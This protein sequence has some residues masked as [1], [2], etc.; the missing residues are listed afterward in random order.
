MDPAKSQ[1]DA[2]DQAQRDA[3]DRSAQSSA[4]R[5]DRLAALI[6]TLLTAH[7]L[8]LFLAGGLVALATVIA[9]DYALWLPAWARFVALA[10]FITG[11]VLYARRWLVPALR[12][13]PDREQLALRLERTTAGQEAGLEGLLASGVGLAGT[14]A[15]APHAASTQVNAQLADQPPS[16]AHAKSD[17]DQLSVLDALAAQRTLASP[18]VTSAASAL[19]RLPLSRVLNLRPALTS[20]GALATITLAA[21]ALLLW[22]PTLSLIGLERALIPI[23]S[24]AWPKTQDLRDVT[25]LRVHAMGQALALR[26]ALVKGPGVGP[27][28]TPDPAQLASVQVVTHW[29][30]VREGSP[31]PERSLGASYQGKR[32]EVPPRD[33]LD[34]LREPA[35][36]LFERLLDPATLA[37]ELDDQSPGPARLPAGATVE[38]EYW[39]ST[40]RDRTS[41]QR[42]ELVPPPAVLAAAVRVEPPPY[43]RSLAVRTL[44]AGPGDDER[45][46]ISGVLPGSR[47]KLA[48]T[49]SKPV[50][51][52]W[53]DAT[54]TT[55][56]PKAAER[57]A[58]ELGPDVARLLTDPRADLQLALSEDP[59]GPHATLQWTHRATLRVRAA[60]SDAFGITPINPG[61]FVVELR[62]DKPPEAVVT[63]PALDTQALPTAKLEL[64]GQATDD[65]ALRSA[66]LLVQHARPPS[67]SA[68]AP[69]E[70][71][72][73]ERTLARQEPTAQEPSSAP[74]AARAPS[75]QA[76]TLTL[77]HALDLASVEPPLA[78]GDELWI[79]VLARDTFA[80]D[81]Q[82]HEPVRSPVRK[83]RV[84]SPDQFLEQLWGELSTLRR[85][86]QRQAD[87]QGEL[88]DL[89]SRSADAARAAREQPQLAEQIDRSRAALARV[90]ESL[91]SSALNDEEMAGVLRDAAAAIQQAQQAAQEAGQQ[92]GAAARAQQDPQQNP[93]A[94]SQQAQAKQAI[95]ER[96][97]QAQQALEQA[98]EALDRGQDT[99]AARKSIERLLREQQALQE[100]SAELGRAH[101]GQQPQQLPAQ[102]QRSVRELAE[103]QEQLARR[104]D[105]AF[106]KLEQRAE[107][108]AKTDPAA[109]EALREAARQGRQGGA[110]DQMQQAARSARQNQQQSAQQSQRK[111]QEA[112]SRA[113]A[114]LQDQ[115][116]SRDAVLRRAI[117]SLL[118]AI[119]ALIAQQELA[120]AALTKTMP[121]G[122]FAGLDGPMLR[123][124]TATLSAAQQAREAAR[125]LRVA[126]TA[127]DAAKDEQM[128]AITALRA[129]PADA[130]TALLA[131]QAS[132]AKLREA[133][134]LVQEADQQAQGREQSRQRAELARS[135]EQALA[136]QAALRAQTQPLAGQALDRRS[137]SVARALAEAQEELVARLAKLREGNKGLAD[138]Q[139][140]SLAH[141]RLATAGDQAAQGLREA[142]VPASVTLRQQAIERILRQLASALADDQPQDQAFREPEN[143]GAG[144]GGS[145]GSGSNP[146]LIPPI[147]QLKLLRSMQDEALTLTREADMAQAAKP[148]DPQARE[149]ARQLA[150]EARALQAQ[151]AQQAQALLKAMQPPAG[152]EGGPQLQRE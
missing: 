5:L 98:A 111:A 44:D 148:D 145:S 120:S 49:Y 128:L 123:L 52:Q 31:G 24:V 81:G 61:V 77:Q 102:A 43:A 7:R 87:K 17:A 126:A 8:A 140:F 14:F 141:E 33:E 18:V 51:T 89:T 86:V 90:R 20:L 142:S 28:G 29:R 46:L 117:A 91:T 85:E 64:A 62:Q 19:Q 4:Q 94:Q 124:H 149:S 3:A 27:G 127:L 82:E 37:A 103:Q 41:P 34:T 99:W 136:D 22:Q 74:P 54:T 138:A 60:P 101:A 50:P 59:Q 113:L 151:V 13:R 80:L 122:P 150:L 38:L 130:A 132:L 121:H 76:T 66:E 106:R 88:K 21:L 40:A 42:I 2:R 6:R 25:G 129:Q 69:A 53:L 73:P 79:T 16:T 47:V 63:A 84:I 83:V 95:Q 92:A 32:V 1:P 55:P 36:P 56:N 48:I 72:G 144:G 107:Q 68:G 112:L 131:Q 146:P 119:D 75:P 23:S 57:L 67:G 133:R 134:R 118:E 147:A 45:A 115:A 30:I 109:A 100:R 12:F 58:A 135:Y 9:I 143:A 35:G 139:V 10:G 105:E 96:Q 78:P 93:K 114:P 26:A 97:A 11:G 15:T 125:A 104:T 70:P 152:P 137:R 108:A 116:R 65:V 110:S 39:F 71:L